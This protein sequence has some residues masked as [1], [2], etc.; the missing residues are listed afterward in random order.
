MDKKRILVIDDDPVMTE[1]VI[2]ALEE[3]DVDI[4]PSGSGREGLQ[5]LYALRPDLVILDVMMPDMDGW[6]ICRIIRQLSEVPIIMLTSQADD[7]QVDEEQVGVFRTHANL[8]AGPLHAA[9]R[10]SE[11][12]KHSLPTLCLSMCGLA[13][14]AHGCDL[15]S[16]AP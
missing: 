12:G 9:G 16:Q 3:A 2:A 8:R 4:Y 6:E 13:S 14:L 1:L 15:A 5:Q 11:R 7:R 10:A